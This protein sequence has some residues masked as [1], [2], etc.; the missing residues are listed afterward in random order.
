MGVRRRSSTAAAS[1]M[2][3]RSTRPATVRS[4]GEGSGN[5]FALLTRVPT[6]AMDF[7]NT[8]LGS[9]ETWTSDSGATSTMILFFV[10]FLYYTV[11]QGG[12]NVQVANGKLLPLVG[13]GKLEIVAE[14][15]KGPVTFSLGKVL[16]GPKLERNLISERQVSLIFGLLFVKRP[17]DANLGTGKDNMCFFFIIFQ[18]FNIVRTV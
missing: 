14:Y 7:L 10:G 5:E 8:S 1:S 15:P 17:M 3:V 12:R 9:C 18:L 11:G 6:G 2:A 16:N 4:A 13:F